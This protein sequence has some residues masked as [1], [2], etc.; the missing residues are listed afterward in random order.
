MVKENW[1]GLAVPIKCTI[2]FTGV[3]SALENIGIQVCEVSSDKLS[4]RSIEGGLSSV[5]SDLLNLVEALVDLLGVGF[6]LCHLLIVEGVELAIKL[7]GV[8]LPS[9]SNLPHG[10]IIDRDGGG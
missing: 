6:E 3:F 1:A 7:S 10:L 2:F 8:L 4:K 5:L 9:V